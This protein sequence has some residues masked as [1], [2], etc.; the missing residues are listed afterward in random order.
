ME[1]SIVLV[2]VE[3]AVAAINLLNGVIASL[4]ANTVVE[5]SQSSDQLTEGHNIVIQNDVSEDWLLDE[6]Y[7]GVELVASLLSCLGIAM[8]ASQ[9]NWS[10]KES[11]ALLLA[12]AAWRRATGHRPE[13]VHALCALASKRIRSNRVDLAALALEEAVESCTTLYGEKHVITGNVILSLSQ[14]YLQQG[15]LEKADVYCEHALGIY[16]S[17]CGSGH[18]SEGDVLRD[19]SLIH[20]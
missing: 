15:L 3:Q 8:A 16:T 19:L 5:T 7:W 2:R 9:S 4:K 13:L 12:V 11:K 17:L 10:S 6:D 1:H 18:F 20:I 14:V